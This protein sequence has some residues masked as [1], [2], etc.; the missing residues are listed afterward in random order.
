MLILIAL[1]AGIWRIRRA[2]SRYARYRGMKRSGHREPSDSRGESGRRSLG[3]Q[4]AAD[5]YLGYT[6]RAFLHS[7]S[8]ELDRDVTSGT[9]LGG[10]PQFRQLARQHFI[11]ELIIAAPRPMTQAIS[12]VEKEREL[13]I[14][15]RVV[16]AFY[17]VLALGLLAYP[18]NFPR[19]ALHHRNAPVLESVGK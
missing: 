2:I 4:I 12:I 13:D 1:T 3:R 6:L 18:G 5:R 19:I 9:V 7:S 8:G 16:L 15:V 14:D 17:S 11:D 10:I